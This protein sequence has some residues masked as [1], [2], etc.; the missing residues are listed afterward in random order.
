MIK[1][2]WDHLIN[3]ALKFSAGRDDAII[4]IG[5]EIRQ[6]EIIYFINDN[7]VGFNMNYHHKLFGLFQQLH[8]D[9]TYGG[10][11]VGLAISKRIIT[12]HNGRIW[13][14]S[15]PGVGTTFY[16]SLPAVSEPTR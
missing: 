11:G 12:K 15:Q 10:I 13:A 16:F 9:R 1:E 4:E 6:D 14:D 2:V 5:S 8:D 3:N 7:G